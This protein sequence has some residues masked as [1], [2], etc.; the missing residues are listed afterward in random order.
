MRIDIVSIFPEMLEAFADHGIVA[1]ARAQGLVDISLWN[2]RDYADNKHRNVDD[3]PYGGGPGMVLQVQPLQAAIQAAQN[4]AR[5]AAGA[6]ANGTA[7]GKR[8][9]YLSPQGRKLDHAGVLELAAAPE[10]LLV[11]GRYEGIDE[12]LFRMEPGEEWSIGDYVLSGGEA[13]AMV[14]VDAV[15]RQLPGALGDE[16][17]AHQDSFAQGLLDYAHYTRPEDYRGYKVPEVLLSGDHRR[18]ARWRLKQA[19]GRTWLRRPD[20]LQALRLDT[21]QQRLLAEFQQEYQ[22]GVQNE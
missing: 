1:R 7:K 14:M 19:L 8:L 22:T 18:I 16:T 21:E 4:A 17:S 5:A 10:L 11:A 9:I 15:V 3:R 12:R 13:A 20:L 6:M 2:P